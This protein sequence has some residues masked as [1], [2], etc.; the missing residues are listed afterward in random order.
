[1]IV[2]VDVVAVVAAVQLD[3]VACSFSLMSGVA[4]GGGERRQPVLVGDDAV[5]RLAGWE[6]AGP[7]DE[8]GHAVGAFPVAVL[9]A[10]ERRGAGVGP[11]VVV[12]AVVGRVVGRS[13]CR[14]CPVRRA[15]RAARRRA[16]R[17]RP[18]RRGIRRRSGRQ[19]PRVLLLDVRAE[20]HPRAVPPAEE[21]LAG[22][23]LPLDE[24][25]GGGD[26]LV[27]DRLHP[28]LGERAGVFDRLAAL[29][30]GLALEHAARAVLLEERLAVGQAPCR[31]V[32]AVL[33]LFLGVEVVEVA[34]ELVEA[35]HRRQVLVAI[36][37]V[38][39]AEL[40]GG[41]ALRSSG[42]WRW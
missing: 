16:C 28:L 21:R 36:A 39:L 9:L 15:G 14:R 6:F 5:E 27:V 12:R 32:V 3:A 19:M 35:V 7:A 37:L 30:V 11:G 10:A 33:G 20:V 4:G 23:V 26:G 1:M 24:V 13:Y 42:P 2:A 18:C 40:A 29:A 25:L 17:A 41:V 22:L 38:V 8:R 31:R 34:E